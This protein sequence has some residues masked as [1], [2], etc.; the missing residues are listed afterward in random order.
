MDDSGRKSLRFI[1]PISSHYE[2]SIELR[3]VAQE[4]SQDL[5]IQGGLEC[6]P[7]PLVELNNEVAMQHQKAPC[8]ASFARVGGRNTMA[9]PPPGVEV[10]MRFIQLLLPQMSL[11]KKEGMLSLRP[12]PVL[13]SGPKVGDIA[14]HQVF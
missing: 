10:L 12:Y 7:C 3:Q 6:F 4:L 14:K 13:N 9:A 5:S 11:L 1:L 8:R 2:E